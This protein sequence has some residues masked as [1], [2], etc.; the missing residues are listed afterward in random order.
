MA[1]SSKKTNN[2]N[3]V[4]PNEQPQPASPR[5]T[6]HHQS[7]G[8]IKSGSDNG[9]AA[10]VSQNGANTKHQQHIRVLRVWFDGLTREE[11]MAAMGFVDET[12]L[13]AIMLLKKRSLAEATPT[14]ATAARGNEEKNSWFH[15]QAGGAL[16]H[17]SFRL[18]EWDESFSMNTIVAA[19]HECSNS[20]QQ[21]PP[22]DAGCLSK[23]QLRTSSPPIIE[24]AEKP[25]FLDVF[26][27][28]IKIVFPCVLNNLQ[29]K[30]NGSPAP[31]P[32]AR[33][34][35]FFTTLDL[36]LGVSQKNALHHNHA[37][38][39]M[40][41]LDAIS[42]DFYGRPFLSPLADTKLANATN[43]NASSDARWGPDWLLPGRGTGTSIRVPL[44]VLLLSRLE[45]EVAFAFYQRQQ[46]QLRQRRTS[47]GNSYEQRSHSILGDHLGG[48][49]DVTTIKL[50]LSQRDRLMNGGV[51]INHDKCELLLQKIF[52]SVENKIMADPV[53]FRPQ[54]LVMMPVAFLLTIALCSVGSKGKRVSLNEINGRL[55]SAMAE[56]RRIAAASQLTQAHIQT[57]RNAQGI[58]TQDVSLASLILPARE[59]RQQTPD[60]NSVSSGQFVEQDGKKR[61]GKKKKKKNK[62]KNAFETANQTS[63]RNV[64]VSSANKSSN[65]SV[66]NSTETETPPKLPASVA[67]CD[68]NFTNADVDA[69][70][71]LLDSKV[72]MSAKS[73]GAEEGSIEISISSSPDVE[74]DEASSMKNSKDDDEWETVGNRSRGRKKVNDVVNSN[75]K[76]HTGESSARL[77]SASDRKKHKIENRKPAAAAKRNNKTSRK[78][79]REII[80]SV[81]DGVDDEVNNHSGVPPTPTPLNSSRSRV[82]N[83]VATREMQFSLGWQQNQ[84]ARNQ[85]SKEKKELGSLETTWR[86]DVRVQSQQYQPTIIVDTATKKNSPAD[87]ST[88]PTFQETASS[89]STNTDKE[90]K[91]FLA[92]SKQNRTPVKTQHGRIVYDLPA[93]ATD[94]NY[95]SAHQVKAFPLPRLLNAENA[96]STTSSV[97]SSLEAP[98][99]HSHQSASAPI[100][101]N[102]VGFHLLD[103]CDRLSKD[104][105][106]F[107]KSRGETVSL[108]R[109]ER[110]VILGA[111]QE[112]VSRIW[113]NSCRVE[114]YG[115]CATLLDLPSSDLDVVITGLDRAE[116]FWNSSADY[117]RSA[118]GTDDAYKSLSHTPHYIPFYSP[119]AHRVMKLSA[120]IEP[121]PWAVQVKSIPN[122]TVPVIKILADPSKISGS[123][124]DNDWSFT[125]GYIAM[126]EEQY[127]NSTDPGVG[128]AE[129]SPLP[130]STHRSYQPWRG[131]DIMNGLISLDIT[132]EGPEH[133]GIGSTEYSMHVVNQMCQETG[134]SPDD[135]P[136]VQCLMVLKELLAQRKLNEPYSGGLSSYALLLLLTALLRE[137][138]AIR[139]E[140]ERSLHNR[141]SSVAM[142]TQTPSEETDMLQ[143]S[144]NRNEIHKGSDTEESQ[145]KQNPP[146]VET[147]KA[148]TSWASV[149]RKTE[150]RKIEMKPAESSTDGK[151]DLNT[152]NV[153]KV[154]SETSK[155]LS[156]ADAVSKAPT[157][158]S[159]AQTPP[160]RNSSANA[161]N[162]RDT[163]TQEV[164]Q[165]S[166]PAEGNQREFLPYIQSNYHSAENGRQPILAPA[167]SQL[168][169]PFFP[170][171]FDDVIE[172]L[173][174]GETTSG[175]LLMHFLLHYG[176]YFDANSTAIDVSGKHGRA[177]AVTT[178]YTYLTPFM[179][180]STPETFDPHTGMLIVDHIVIYDPLEGREKFNVGRKCFAWPHVRWIFAQSYATLVSAV[181]KIIPA[182]VAQHARPEGS[183]TEVN[184][185]PDESVDREGSVDL[186][187]PSS[188]LLKCL[189]SF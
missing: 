182:E 49:E 128:P 61:K 186:V 164:Y 31:A 110:A 135:T 119:N 33:R 104:M 111:L 68:T 83:N 34:N 179:E 47:S 129:L 174:L 48:A 20:Q 181:E 127:V 151:T 21:Q 46:H 16:N 171:G 18:V 52:G 78:I 79:A 139:A 9:G 30:T 87:Q 39:L 117:M 58:T 77:D 158:R 1:N 169:P 13:Y 84:H 106:L 102:A 112:S 6:Q 24:A 43:V 148:T 74:A 14:A 75:G 55:E 85:A 120:E 35:T 96:N 10:G 168:G 156:F 72:C 160:I 132:F 165:E 173:C 99:G 64:S 94:L 149:A 89:L 141:Q 108:R 147:G 109:S 92:L 67:V 125:S 26:V 62:S 131:S 54:M 2:K 122:A 188:Q 28:N 162:M 23:E 69:A 50:V 93:P 144:E 17:R 114:L 90:K 163:T 185:L 145:L 65:I 167:E 76:S 4:A 45:A 95:S 152:R 130:V 8:K 53:P 184:V 51:Q 22:K 66:S 189:I 159:Q 107:M 42:N 177:L 180:R 137:R 103:V 82:G 118:D 101:D 12:F 19:W 60:A 155:P 166:S 36:T 27:S 63:N 71:N 124:H 123:V 86:G 161:P 157:A 133:G 98:H 187:D 3:V 176:Q 142:G 116:S 7:M 38:K 11:R 146:V 143:K 178:P 126:Q 175:K 170:Q 154:S 44:Y 5:P 91:G 81:L 37:G 172:I 138:T 15:G 32:K 100:D 73:G 80:F 25:H 41:S 70:S 57:K 113:P 56:I 40:E 29:S 150:S 136:F 121:L 134:L 115:S 183:K 59:D 88:A 153:S 105:A 97:G 140:I